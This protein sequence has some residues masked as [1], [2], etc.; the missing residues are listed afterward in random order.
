M[1]TTTKTTPV[2]ERRAL[3]A[4]VTPEVHEGW[5]TFAADNGVTVSALLEVIGGTL[6]EAQPM[7]GLTVTKLVLECRQI[8]AARR[9]RTGIN[10]RG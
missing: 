1:P 5:H 3:H 8:D 4:F 9:R 2:I 7:K 6:S 10:R